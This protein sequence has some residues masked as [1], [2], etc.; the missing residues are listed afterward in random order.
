MRR[1]FIGLV[2]FILTLA[3][4]F[5]A[6]AKDD[7]V[8]GDVIVL[9]K[10][11]SVSANSTFGIMAEKARVSQVAVKSGAKVK[12]N[13]TALSKAAGKSF[14]LLHSDT[15]SAEKLLKEL[16]KNPD[17]LGVSLNYV[18]HAFDQPDDEY[19]SKLWGPHAISADKLWDEGFTGTAS[20]YVAVLDTGIS[21]THSDLAANFDTKGYSRNFSTASD[22]SDVKGHGSHV[23]GTIAA[24]GNNGI[25]VTGV[26]WKAKVFALKVLGD[27]GKGQWAWTTEALNYLCELVDANPNLNL[28]SINLSL[29]GWISKTPDEMISG[30]D[31]MWAAFKAFSDKNRAVIC[32]SAG[33]ESQEVGKVGTGEY[34][35]K[36]V[37]PASFKNISNMIVVAAA[38]NNSS[39]SKAYYSNYSKTYVDVSAPGSGIYSTIPGNSYGSKSGTSMA[40]PHVTG[41]AALLKSIIPSATASQIKAAIKSGA[42]TKIA[43]DY[44]AS[45]FLD[46]KKALQTLQSTSKTKPKILTSSL[47]EGI[48]S[49][50]YGVMLSA[51]GATPMTWT[52]KSG[53]LPKGLT[54]T[55]AGWLGGTPTKAGSYTFTLQAKNSKGTDTKKFTVNVKLYDMSITSS[56]KDA[57]N[58]STYYDY[59]EVSGG[60]AN[61]TWKKVSGTVPNGLSLSYSGNRAILSGTPTKPGTYTF[62][63]RATDKNKVTAEK[64]FTVQISQYVITINYSFYNATMGR[65][66]SDWTSASNGVMPYTWKK[67]SGDLP[68]GLTL[69]YSNSDN[70][71]RLTGTPKVPGTYNFKL[72]VTDKNKV[73]AERTFAI[74]VAMPSLSISYTFKNGALKA[75]YSDYVSVSGGTTPYTVKK[76]SGTL[77]T[78]LKLSVSGSSVYLKGT[79]TKAGTYKFTLRVTDK[80]NKITVDKSF[81][82]QITKP[83]F[84]STSYFYDGTLK[85]S[86]SDYVS[87]SGGTTPYTVKK[88]SGTLPNGLK[89]SMSGSYVY[90]TGTPTKAGAFT[91]TLRVTD[92]NKVTAD[93]AFTVNIIAPEMLWTFG[94]GTLKT[95]YGDYVTISGGTAPYTWSKTSGTIPTGLKLKYSGA[96]A[97]LYGTPTATGTFKFTLKVTDANKAA[98]SKTFTVKIT[99]ASSSSS[100][101]SGTDTGTKGGTSSGVVDEKKSSSGSKSVVQNAPSGGGKSV[102]NLRA[103]LTVAEDDIVESYEGKDSDLVKVRAGKPLNFTVSGWSKDVTGV[104]VY[105]DEKALKNIKVT[106]KGTFTL[107]AEIVRGDFKVSVKA[108]ELESEELFI[109]AD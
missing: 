75:V 90:L 88:V 55:K 100:K 72:R 61:Y 80:Q 67:V 91:F 76:V 2:V 43:K 85:A 56:F 31:P 64:E 14:A 8:P 47:P 34:A 70:K 102:N 42:N 58:G 35:G 108:G 1:K 20:T 101:S 59:V 97:M 50:D 51:Q 15:Q 92:A 22:Y 89:V 74:T 98:V 77:P 4:S 33:N 28:A 7:V 87:V 83:E 12:K 32:V 107:P 18:V 3:F 45:G 71:V 21:Y 54:L 13:Y 62:K 84:S 63:L 99:K 39:Y 29:G 68:P 25:G 66:Y 19:Y 53:T 41:A 5:T 6:S 78:G 69:S 36:Y 86:Y 9:M 23:A 93:R 52:K 95:A 109:I 96:V 65:E 73:T 40:A 60:Y 17:V 11:P 79:P 106:K 48:V 57:T 24:V 104:T 82:V 81:V 27:D 105:V 26:N 49:E 10:A 16:K 46:V 38:D 37:Y 103:L 30:N 44:T 94:N